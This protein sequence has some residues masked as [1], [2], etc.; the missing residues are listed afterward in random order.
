MVFSHRSLKFLNCKR[1]Q[2]LPSPL[3][4]QDGNSFQK[5]YVS[6]LVIQFIVD[7]L[8]LNCLLLKNI[9][10]MSLPFY[11]VN[12]ELM[13]GNRWTFFGDEFSFDDF[14]LFFHILYR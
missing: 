13:K 14:H 8:D 7:A 10:T 1:V 9:F 12:L 2:S 3:P 6:K 11:H 5:L 4:S